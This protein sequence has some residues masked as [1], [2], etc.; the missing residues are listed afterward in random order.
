VKTGVQDFAEGE[1]IHEG[2]LVG[3]ELRPGRYVYLEVTDD[4]C[5]MD[6][7]TKA[8][9]FDPFFST[10]FTGRGLGLAAVFGIVRGH[11]A[12]VKVSSKVNEGSCFRVLFPAVK[13]EVEQ[14]A[15]SKVSN[16][17]VHGSGTIL[18]V[19]DEDMV[20]EM[21][22]L[23]LERCGY[24]VLLAE[25]GVAAIDMVK[26]HPGEISLV[27][28][29]LAMPGMSGEETLPELRKI[30]PGIRVVLSSGYSENEMLKALQGQNIAGFIQ[31]PYTSTWLAEQVQL[32]MG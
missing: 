30:R 2:T 18:V 5:G 22:R 15:A 11:K 21:S 7:S 14:A 16:A 27:V 9:I 25:S 3:A 29:D 32:A 6:E 20:R 4:G 8:R 19:D 13:I 24:R 1:E 23:T 28:L 26:R 10:K 17:P 12:T 31:K